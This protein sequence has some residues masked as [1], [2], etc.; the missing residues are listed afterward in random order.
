MMMRNGGLRLNLVFEKEME[1]ESLRDKKEVLWRGERVGHS[2][3]EG[4]ETKKKPERRKKE[5]FW[6]K[7]L[8]REKGAELGGNDN[9]KWRAKIKLGF[10]ERN[11]GWEFEG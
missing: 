1:G 7:S 6:E 10:W 2:I 3:G 8:R 9:E 11:E 4:E 5:G